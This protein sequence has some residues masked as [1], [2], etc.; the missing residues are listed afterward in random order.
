M[1]ARKMAG[2]KELPEDEAEEDMDEVAD[3]VME[4]TG[5]VPPTE[6]EEP[7]VSDGV[8]DAKEEEGGGPGE[9]PAKQSSEEEAN[10]EDGGNS[11]EKVKEQENDADTTE[12]PRISVASSWRR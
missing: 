2:R 6:V 10:R 9:V 11:V 5:E 3:I 7:P 4:E 8:G 1:R 12:D